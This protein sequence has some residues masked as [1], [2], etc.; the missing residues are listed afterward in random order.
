M[1]RM[2][3]YLSGA[4]FKSRQLGGGGGTTA[5]GLASAGAPQLTSGNG[6]LLELRHL[7]LQEAICLPK[8]DRGSFLLH[9]LLAQK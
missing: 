6:W 7:W 8:A 4:Q 2:V 5:G 3:S 1:K 9:L